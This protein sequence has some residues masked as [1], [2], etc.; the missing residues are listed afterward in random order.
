KLVADNG[1]AHIVE[2]LASLPAGLSK[3][4]YVEAGLVGVQP[5]SR[6]TPTLGSTAQISVPNDNG[7]QRQRFIVNESILKNRLHKSG[8]E[9]CSNCILDFLQVQCVVSHGLPLSN[10]LRSP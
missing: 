10:S 8:V 1:V 3:H 4:Y 6:E 5:C 9:I 2:N 7:G